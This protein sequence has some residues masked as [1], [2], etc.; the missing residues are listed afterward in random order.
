MFCQ[1]FQ[2]K[3]TVSWLKS[4]ARCFWRGH[5]VP[6]V[7]LILVFCA[8]SKALGADQQDPLLN[9]L[10]QK[11]ILTE[12][13]AK[14]VQA[15]A[16]A[17]RTNALQAPPASKWKIG[18]GIKSIELFGDLRV[19]YEYRQANVPDNRRVELD[20]GRYAV[21]LGLRGEAFDDFYYGVR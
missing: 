13:E 10:L 7:A 21:R 18:N 3:T 17:S 5:F 8:G 2:P 4:L 14:K 6:W 1:I 19:R 12:D 15:E 9:L 11:G 20:R 16:D